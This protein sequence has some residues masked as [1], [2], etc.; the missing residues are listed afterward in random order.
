MAR[1]SVAEARRSQL[2]STYGSR[3]ALPGPGRELHDRG[4]R[5]LGECLPEVA[6][7]RL[8][9]SLGVH[10]FRMPPSGVGEPRMFRWCASRVAPLPWCD[11]FGWLNKFCGW[12]EHT[13]P[14]CQRTLTPSG[15]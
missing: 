2:V 6:E 15:S 8:A 12:D 11:R 7:P 5:R 14:S 10:T 13:V 4:S 9:R 3:R 1:S